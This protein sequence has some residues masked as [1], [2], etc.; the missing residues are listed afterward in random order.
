MF[1]R[2]SPHLSQTF[3]GGG[4]LPQF[5][6]DG[7]IQQKPAAKKILRTVNARHRQRGFSHL[8]IHELEQ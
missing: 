1:C 3:C 5:Q 2:F 7:P 6:S 4:A 8:T